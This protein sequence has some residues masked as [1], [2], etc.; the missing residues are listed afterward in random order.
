M[1]PRYSRPEMSRIWS[2]ENRFRTWL[3][4]EIAAAEVLADQGVVPRADLEEI[5]T[6]ARFDVARIEA[7]EQEVQHDV[8]AFVTCVA[9]SVG[10]AGSHG[11]LGIALPSTV[12]ELAVCPGSRAITL[13]AIAA[14]AA[15]S[16]A[17]G[18]F[19]S[20]RT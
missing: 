14:S 12:G 3:A 9:E 6:K 16:R 8:I 2:E 19:C 11:W 13:P 10:P 18:T 17:I 1:I 20:S 4:V 5:R 7:I 15:S